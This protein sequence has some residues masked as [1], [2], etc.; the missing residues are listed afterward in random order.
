MPKKL[1]VESMFRIETLLILRDHYE[2]GISGYSLADELEAITHKRPSSGKI[3]PFLKELATR[4]FADIIHLDDGRNKTLYKLTD[5][6]IDLCDEIIDKMRNLL[7][8]KLEL[9][10]N[11]CHLC[12]VAL[13]DPKVIVV[14]PDTGKKKVYCCIHCKEAD[15]K[16]A[17]ERKKHQ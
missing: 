2:E 16:A 12:G 9:I 4:G 15:E 10:F 14:D 11:V 8:I 13:Y 6:G 17:A 3:Y 1:K 5:E 7:D